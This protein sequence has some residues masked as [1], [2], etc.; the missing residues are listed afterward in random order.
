MVKYY[1][2]T[3]ELKLK[4]LEVDTKFSL[5]NTT[6]YYLLV[7][8]D[9]FE[10]NGNKTYSVESNIGYTYLPDIY[11]KDDV[12]FDLENRII[13]LVGYKTKVE[14]VSYGTLDSEEFD[15]YMSQMNVGKVATKLCLDLALKDFKPTNV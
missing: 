9:S 14:T 8:K 3:N 10:F 5:E 4:E 13:D 11:I 2:I 1:V 7:E 6:H 12:E 15:E